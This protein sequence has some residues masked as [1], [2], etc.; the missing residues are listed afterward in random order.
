MELCS[1]GWCAVFRGNY[2]LYEYVFVLYF[3]VFY[4]VL[5]LQLYMHAIFLYIHIYV[6]NPHILYN[7]ILCFKN[8]IIS[9]MTN[10]IILAISLYF[11]L[12]T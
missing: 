12:I 4:Y 11:A 3:M 6:D 8:I 9:L 2:Y 5:Y 10:N 1:C 7:L